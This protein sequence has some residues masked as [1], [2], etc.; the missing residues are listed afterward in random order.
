MALTNEQRESL[1]V[2]RSVLDRAC[3]KIY[4]VSKQLAVIKEHLNIE[5]LHR[6]YDLLD[7]AYL[8]LDRQLDTVKDS[9]KEAAN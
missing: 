5:E 6:A 9:L 2:T 3:S 8:K 7:A 4:E 1:E